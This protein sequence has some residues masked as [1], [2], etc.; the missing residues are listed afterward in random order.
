MK[1]PVLRAL[2]CV[3]ATALTAA[4]RSEPPAQPVTIRAGLLLDGLGNA[5]PDAL[6][7]LQ[8][9]RITAVG[10]YTG[11]PVTHDLSGYTVLP[12]LIDAHVHISGYITSRGR[13]NTGGDGETEAQRAAGRAANALATLR[14]GFTTVASMGAGEDVPLRD[15]IARGEIPGPRIL[16]SLAALSDTTPSPFRLRRIL[17]LHQTRGADFIKIMSTNSVREGGGPVFT[18]EQLTALC[19]E[20][21]RAGLRSVVHVQSDASIAMAVTAG[22]DQLEHGMVSTREALLPAAAAG[23]AFDPQCGLVLDN[24]LT[25]RAKVEGMQGFM[26]QSFD[27]ME[28]LLPRMPGVIR[29]ALTVPDLTLLYGTDATAG[30]HGQNAEDLVCR[31]REAGESPM[32]ALVSATSRN[33]AAYGLAGE[34]GSIVPGLQADLIALE[35]N[36]LEAIE[37]VRRVRFVM[38]GGK[39]FLTP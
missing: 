12:G 20:A 4:C 26:P 16:T 6:V 7:T 18:L 31:V 38:K 35:G 33:A 22:C 3:C 2:L 15:A 1:R 36:P 25:N 27:L 24:Y 9:S 11:G 17:R 30:A 13:A 34:I 39:T 5:T 29:A 37:S 23:V 32:H 10:P 14:A 19:S 8:G 21:R 28:E